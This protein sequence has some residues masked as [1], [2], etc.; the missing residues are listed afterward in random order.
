MK[1]YNTIIKTNTTLEEI[2]KTVENFNND[3]SDNVLCTL[4]K[5]SIE[6][7]LEPINKKLETEFTD[8]FLITMMTD[9]KKAFTDLLETPCYTK[10]VVIE[11]Q[12]KTF[13]IDD[14]KT[15]LF[16]FS[17]LEK[18]YQLSKSKETDK[19]GKA[20]PNKSVTIFDA[21]RFYGLMATFIR[22]L[23]KSNFEIDEKEGYSLENVIID[24][25]RQFSEKDGKVFASNSN[26]ALKDQTDILVKFF[27]YDVHLIKKDLPIL[28]IKAQK[29]KQDRKN[30][31]FTVNAIIDDKMILQF[32]D[33]IFG[34]IA[35]RITGKDIDIVTSKPKKT[36]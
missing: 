35:S 1:N 17:T 30:A 14:T 3:L 16:K 7:A 36:K 34:V 26:N 21:L 24:E 32:A 19:N 6:K 23:Q 28:K 13:K 31:K 2:K 15:V 27:G 8:K 4:E 10:I 12:N 22:N 33:V 5:A 20:I 11:N 25:K 29:L 18:A 9:R